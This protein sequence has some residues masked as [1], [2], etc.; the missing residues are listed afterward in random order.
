MSQSLSALVD[1]HATADDAAAI[2]ALWRSDASV[3]ERW[4]RYHLIGDVLRSEELAQRPDHD[5]EFLSCLRQR[6]A[7]EQPPNLSL[8]A[9]P[10]EGDEQSGKATFAQE[11]VPL[12]APVP[13]QV[14]S[15][16]LSWP[17]ASAAAVV[18]FLVV[19]GVMLVT[20]TTPD[21]A[22][23]ATATNAAATSAVITLALEPA[24]PALTAINHRLVRD[25]QLDR[26]LAAHRRVSTVASVGLPGAVVR[27]VDLLAIDDK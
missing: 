24:G 6:L 18:G 13:A 8:R 25:A 19:A 12:R 4:H 3:R 23:I 26:Y 7:H 5:A 27:R 9:R 14:S 10:P 15:H 16:R 17:M 22:S 21:V 1:G 11:S 2:G 20:R